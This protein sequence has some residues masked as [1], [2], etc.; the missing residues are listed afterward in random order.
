MGYCSKSN[1]NTTADVITRLT[2]GDDGKV[3][4]AIAAVDAIIDAHVQGHF[5]VPVSPVPTLLQTISAD[6]ALHRLLVGRADIFTVPDWLKDAVARHYALLERIQ[7]GE[8][9]LGKQPT[10]AAGEK[11]VA[12]AEVP[13]ALM[14]D[15]TLRE[16]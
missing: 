3:T 2:D 16:F 13:D 5:A 7:R 8:L 4:A 10:P 12:T 1:L 11:A 6:L 15:A 9:D 14:T